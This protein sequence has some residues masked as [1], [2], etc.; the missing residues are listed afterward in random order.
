MAA[1][2][3]QVTDALDQYE[4]KLR[5]AST[6][7][8]KLTD[9]VKDN[10][11][12]VQAAAGHWPGLGNAIEATGGK[13]GVFAAKFGLVTAAFSEGWS[14]GM[15]L[16][17]L[18]GTDMSLWEE[19]VARFG[20]KAGAIVRSLSD[21]VVGV[22][23]LVTALLSGNIGEI[24]RAIGELKDNLVTSGKT[25]SDVVSKWGND[26]DRL[27]PSIKQTEDALKKTAEA[28]KDLAKEK[29]ALADEVAKV[30]TN[31]KKENEAL[32]KQKKAAEDA[33][34]ATH[35]LAN[36]AEYF[37]RQAKGAADAVA[38]QREEVEKLTRAH[39]ANDPMT[40]RAAE[41]LSVLEDRLASAQKRYKDTNEELKSYTSSQKAAT[42]AS[43]QSTA[44]T[45]QQATA[46]SKAA[47]ETVRWTDENGKV[48]VSIRQVKD[49]TE[50]ATA[51][52]E[53]SA[54][55]TEKVKKEVIAVKDENGKWVITQRE[56]KDSTEKA[57]EA[58]T[59]GAEATK[60]AAAKTADAAKDISMLVA[61]LKELNA[62]MKNTEA[63]AAKTKTAIAEVGDA[64]TK[65]AGEAGAAGAAGAAAGM[66][67]PSSGSGGGGGGG[68]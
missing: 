46:T 56:V 34:L 10:Q 61:A 35:R 11:A 51:A 24:K 8:G 60:A 67:G 48:H 3:K 14:L 36:D 21:N 63:Q 37:G 17:Q 68:F 6:Q 52:T 42:E 1:A 22:V 33:L 38:V 31:L 20:S 19:T 13:A 23:G 66:G 45:T 26:W 62:E 54:A 29:K 58:Q 50:Q 39:G 15:K 41:E 32:E 5:E 49:E 47:I 64:A 12:N 57:A 53:K 18:F 16:N 27:H 44:A 59:K 25:M 4:A 30:E 28:A 43:T 2:P 7:T 40:V 65:A 55:A 9:A